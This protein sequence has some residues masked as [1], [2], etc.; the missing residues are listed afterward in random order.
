MQT[1]GGEGTFYAGAILA[2]Q[3]Y[4]SNYHRTGAKDVMILLSDGDATASAAQ[5]GGTTKQTVSIAGMNNGLFSSTAECTQAV[6]A[7][8][9]AKNLGTQIYSIS[10]GSANTGCNT[11][12]ETY[13][14][15]CATMQGIS[16]VPLSQYFFS[17]PQSKN[18]S[19][20]TV[21]SGAVPITQL[22][23]VF[24]TIA[25]DLTTS[26]LVPNLVF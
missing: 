7:A 22:S 2:A 10:Y 3:A 1:P 24:T 16:S 12:S 5:M 8:T 26:R 4:L 13:K 20:S 25:G 15:P 21:C 19:T 23:Q 6:A 18:G 11:G 14:T 9:Y 17:V